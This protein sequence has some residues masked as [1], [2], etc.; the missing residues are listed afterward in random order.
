MLSM[1][2]QIISNCNQYQSEFYA[3]A[4]EENSIP[5][6]FSKASIDIKREIDAHHREENTKK[7]INWDGHMLKY[8]LSN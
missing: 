4:Q 2:Y 7:Y 5:R 1:K 8:N 3:N 6:L